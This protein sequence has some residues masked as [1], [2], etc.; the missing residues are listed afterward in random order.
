MRE[1]VEVM[2]LSNDVLRLS[3]LASENEGVGL[4]RCGSTCVITCVDSCTATCSS[5]TCGIT[6]RVTALY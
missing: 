3:Q 5:S 2:K 1:V 4:I 6:C